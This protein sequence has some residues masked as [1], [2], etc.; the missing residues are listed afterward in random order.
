MFFGGKV[1]VPPKQKPQKTERAWKNEGGAPAPAKVNR[2]DEEGSDGTSNGGAAVK[3]G[4]CQGAFLL[5][6][7]LRD[8]FGWCRPIRR[9]SGSDEKAAESKAGK[10]VCKTCSH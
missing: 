9:F 5:W 1:E 6:K 4:G 8:G 7:P 3:E 10:A 2:Q